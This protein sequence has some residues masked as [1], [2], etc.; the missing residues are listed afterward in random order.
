MKKTLPIIGVILLIAAVLCFAVSLWFRFMSASVMD[1]TAALH[2]RLARLIRSFFFTGAGLA[3][4]GAALL[5]VR[6]LL[7]HD[8]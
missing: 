5:A 6:I 7:K 1:G 2:A 4:S 3:L 8:Q